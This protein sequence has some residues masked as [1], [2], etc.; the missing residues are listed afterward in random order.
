MRSPH[1]LRSR[2]ALM[3]ALLV[4]DEPGNPPGSGW[5]QP[6]RGTLAGGR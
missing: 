1:S 2:F 3:I 4:A 6:R 5:Q